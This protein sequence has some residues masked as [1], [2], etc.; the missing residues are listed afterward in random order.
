MKDLSSIVAKFKVQGTI[1]EIKPLGTGLINDTYKVNTKEADAPDYVLQRINH[2]IFQ[3]VEMLQSNIT[4]VTNHIRKKL[5]EAGESDIERKVLSF[6]ETE[7][8]KAYWFD[9]DNYWRVMV[10]IPRAKTYETVNPE[11]SNYAGEAFGNFQAMLADIPETLGETIPDFHNMEF[12]L[13][14]LREA[15]AKDAAGRVSE[16]KYYLDEIEKKKITAVCFDNGMVGGEL[17]YI[18]IDNHKTGYQLAQELAEQLD[19]KGQVGIVAGDLK[20]KGHRERVEG[21]EEYMK[22]EPEM[23]VKFVESGYANLQMSE[24][25]VRD[26]MGQYPQIRGIMATSAVTA[27]GLVDELK[28]TDIK[29]VAVDEQEDSLKAVEN[30]QILALAAQ[31]GY[32]IGYETIHYIQN[33]RN[34]KHLKKKYYLNAEI[35]TQDNVKEYRK[36]DESQKY[37]K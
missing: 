28:D 26:L 25:K 34:G 4:A 19:H 14:Q 20:Q 7:E 13:K 8:G 11:Y 27:M 5:T 33:L 32:E 37:K 18:G 3:N 2:A 15:V 35:L 36:K 17:P 12:R 31:S 29:I 10:F 24:Q 23:T 6:L 9:G 16:V 21:F 1:E 22:S 30:G